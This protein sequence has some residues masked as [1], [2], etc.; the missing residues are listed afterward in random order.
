MAFF[1]PLCRMYLC[2][3]PDER[4]AYSV[5]ELT[6]YI[7]SLLEQD[8]VLRNLHVSGEV[9]NLTYHSSGHVYFSIKDQQ[10]S[11]SCVMF[12][13]YAQAAPRIR[14]GEK[15][16]LIGEITVYPPRGSYQMMVKSVQKAGLG[17][18]YQQ[19]LALQEKLRKEGLFEESH[20][21]PIPALPKKI[22]VL[23]SPTGAAVRDIIRTL[24][25]RYNK[26]KVVVIPTVVQGEQ[27]KDSIIQS[28]E[29]AQQIEA[30]VIILARGGGSIEDLWNFN[31][32][33]VAQA[34][35]ACRVPVITGIG[36]ES[37]FTIAD[38]VADLRASTPTAAAEHAVPD[39]EGILA[40]L[41]EYEKQLRRN[42]QYFI[43][44]KRQQLDDYS[45]RLEQAFL[46]FLRQK[47][48]EIDVLEARLKGQDLSGILE[49]GFTLSLK[50][51]KILNSVSSL[52]SGDEIETVFHDGRAR[53]LVQEKTKD[54]TS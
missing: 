34:I 33:E 24:R 49:K 47:Q 37:D 50:D 45:Y 28:L 27:G 44:F 29:A 1:F 46:Q 36:H 17:D 35:Y 54:E 5:S 4:P 22:A 43:D 11:L 14:E 51:G 23:T 13:M 31:E 26:V 9:S 48:H 3:M 32:A 39:K 16:I 40:A 12:R 53:S 21:L 30:D 41:D 15:L 6:F 52:E 8:D 20:K 2:G 19:F 7:K 42:L 18:L 10:S 25:R 38:F